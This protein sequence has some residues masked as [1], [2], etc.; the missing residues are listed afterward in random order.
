MNIKI[1]AVG[2][3]KEKYFRDASEEYLKR[4]SKYSKIDLI[5]VPDDGSTWEI[6]CGV[7]LEEMYKSSYDTNPTHGESK[8]I[9]NI[10]TINTPGTFT[11][12]SIGQ[13]VTAAQGAKTSG[14]AAKISAD[15]A[16]TRAQTSVNQT[17]YTGTYGGPSE[18]VSNIAGYIRIP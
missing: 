5:E 13:A 15:T 6:V 10:A 9:H 14:D 11:G 2:K 16:A 17:W 12:V 8:F 3:L 18:S 7:S 4:L 1:I